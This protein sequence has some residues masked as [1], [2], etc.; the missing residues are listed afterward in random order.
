MKHKRDHPDHL[1]G[2]AETNNAGRF[3]VKP[4][5]LIECDYLPRHDLHELPIASEAPVL[6]EK[7]ETIEKEEIYS[8]TDNS[9][10]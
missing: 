8:E 1:V 9:P 2:I 10:F 4:P 3:P 6:S 5:E 7:T